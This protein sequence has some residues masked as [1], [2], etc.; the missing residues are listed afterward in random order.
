MM[1]HKVTLL[2]LWSFIDMVNAVRVEKRCAALDAMDLIP[3]GQKQFSQ[4]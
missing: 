3:L 4:I 1:Q 2:Y